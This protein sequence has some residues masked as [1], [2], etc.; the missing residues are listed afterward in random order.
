MMTKRKKEEPIT[1]DT[2]CRALKSENG[3]SVRRLIG[4][5]LFFEAR[6][7]G[8]KVFLFR[9]QWDKKPQTITIGHYPGVT[10]A[11]ARATAIAYQELIQQEIDPRRENAEVGQSKTTFKLVAEQWFQK[12]QSTWKDFAR[13]RHLKSL[14]RDI[15]PLIG[16]MSI[17][18]ITKADLL[19]T[20][21]PHEDPG[22]HDVAHRLYARLHA[23]FEFAVGASLTTNYPF[24]GLKK[25]LTPRPK[26][27]NQPAIKP[28]EAHDMMEAL[29]NSNAGK[30]VK[31]YIE[32][33]AHLFTRPKELREAKWC[34]FDLKNSEWTIPAERMKMGVEHWVPLSHQVL[35]LLKELRLLTGFTPYLFNTPTLNKSQPITETSVRKILHNTGY[36]NRHTAHGFRSLASTV[37]HEQS[38][39]RTDAIEAQ[40]AHKVQGVRGVYLRA[41]F[42]QE[43]KELMNWYSEWLANQKQKSMNNTSA[44]ES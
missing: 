23:I 27:K 35:K 7:S 36:K 17:D 38:H 5:G 19:N 11:K 4:D 14:E 40:L 15:F 9:Y 39:F 42:K 44:T 16:N 26:A 10:L 2:Q 32:L 43:R 34:E 21:K 20:I 30:V 12:Y 22:H 41:D 33:L 13:N 31:L 18:D 37:L 28:N 1:K 8:K 29:K 25:A 24:V 6:S 3:K